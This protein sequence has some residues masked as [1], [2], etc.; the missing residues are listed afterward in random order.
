MNRRHFLQAS[1]AAAG[2]LAL[3]GRPVRAALLPEEVGKPGVENANWYAQVARKI[4]FDMHTPGTVENVGRDFNPPAF[5]RAIK[6]AKSQ[7]VCYF[8]RCA[9]AWSYYPTKVG[10]PHPHL[11]RDL[12]GDG[13]KALKAEG[14]RVIAYLAMGNVPTPLVAAHPEWCLVQEDGSLRRSGSD[15]TCSACMFG[16]YPEEQMIAQYREIAET[17]PVDG[18]FLDGVYEMFAHVCYCERCRKAFGRPLPSKPDDPDWRAYRQLQVDR[19]WD[20]IGRAAD[21]VAK[22]RPGCLLGVNWMASAW[23]SVPPPKSIGYLTGDPPIQNENFEAAFHLAAWAWRDKPADLMTQRML[24]SWQD[25]TV[26]TPETIETEFAT[27]LAS[28]GRLFI[29]DLLQPVE[30]KPDPEVMRLFRRCFEYAEQREPVARIGRR[31]SDI[32]ILSS[33]ETLR[34]RAGNWS[35]DDIPLRGALLPLIEDGLTADI[36]YDLDV[37]DQLGNYQALIVPEQAFVGRTAAQAIANFVEKGGGLVVT[38]KLPKAVNP[39]EPDTAADGTIFEELSGLVSEGEHPF[40]LGYLRLRG[41]EAEGFWRDGDDFRPAIPVPGKPAKVQATKARTL[42]P[43]TAPGELYQLGA[44]PP[45]ETLQA[46]ALTLNQ[47]GKGLVMFCALPIAV[48]VWKRGNP[49]AKYLLQKMARRVI[50]GIS[51][52]RIG[53]PAVQIWRSESAGRTVVH[54][55]AYQPDRRTDP[56]Q[57]I[58]RP[59]AITDVRVK[60]Y[61]SRT[62]KAVRAEPSRTAA[63][64]HREGRCLIVDVPS[65]VT[66]TAVVFDWA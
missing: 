5:A 49:G 21:E 18:F 35:T 52:E 62:P 3:T 29:G 28:G 22:V 13:L 10:C 24:H 34:T 57:V 14:I 51:V 31:K 44:K 50:R 12:F 66:Y 30:V 56:P 42:A 48:D 2:G 58:E 38:G 32:A 39:R 46:P 8:A 47:F 25:F 40:D 1:A 16:P 54:L 59:S 6:E 9:Y 11:A 61:D 43:L 65:F 7:A 63:K 20:V 17:Y 55:V 26:R 23:W 33:P 15:L 19:M 36:L 60:L 37:P 45:G 53:T 64:V 4:H 41:T 27:G